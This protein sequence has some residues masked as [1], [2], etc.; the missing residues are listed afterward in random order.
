MKLLLGTTN[1]GK[2]IEMQEALKDFNLEFTTPKDEG[3]TEDVVE[4]GW[5]FMEIAEKKAKHYYDE[6][7]IPTLADDSGIL[8]E[9]LE[10]ELGI[11]TR[12]WG[13]GKEAT[14]QEWIEFFLE[15]MR[16]EKNKKARFVCVLCFIDAKGEEHMFEGSCEGVITENLEAEFLPGLPLSACFKPHGSEKV[17]SALTLEEK[18]KFS[19]RG[20]ALESFKKF[21]HSHLTA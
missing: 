18:A 7:K 2:I 12:R 17:F 15:R 3:I 20:K 1:K 10:K 16:K 4:E 19:H 21:L 8:V 13:A 5:T 9:A 6:T 11:H 14:D